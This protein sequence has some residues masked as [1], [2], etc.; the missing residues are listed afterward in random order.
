MAFCNDPLE[1]ARIVLQGSDAEDAIDFV[2]YDEN[3]RSRHRTFIHIEPEP[4]NRPEDSGSE[5]GEPD[6][7]SHPNFRSTAR[8]F[9]LSLQRPSAQPF[10]HGWLLGRE[11]NEVDLLLIRPVEK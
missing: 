8:Y 3:L 11:I 2:C 1:V 6:I 5:S 10:S 9:K 7:R 4:R